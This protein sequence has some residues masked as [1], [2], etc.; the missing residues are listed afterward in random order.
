MSLFYDCNECK[1]KLY[2]KEN[3]IRELNQEAQQQIVDEQIDTELGLE[4]TSTNLGKF[5]S[6]VLQKLNTSSIPEV[7]KPSDKDIEKYNL[8]VLDNAVKSN[9]LTQLF[10]ELKALPKNALNKTQTNIQAKMSSSDIQK[11]LNDM[12]ATAVQQSEERTIPKLILDELI[13]I[14]EQNDFNDMVKLASKKFTDSIEDE[15]FENL[16]NSSSIAETSVMSD[17]PAKIDMRAY[18][19]GRK[20]NNTNQE[21]NE[22][23]DLLIKYS[24]A[25]RGS[26]SKYSKQLANIISRQQKVNPKIAQRMTEMKSALIN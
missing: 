24:K 13:T 8:A 18:N 6:R 17:A 20:K 16:S 10:K 25:P 1:E 23:S 22:F 11:R 21:L 14:I 26:K 2:V 19:T 3:K 5:A 9:Q 7:S 4:N 15:F 12:I